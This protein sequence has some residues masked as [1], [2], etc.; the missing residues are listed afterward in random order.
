MQTS[1]S[2]QTHRRWRDKISSLIRRQCRTDDNVSVTIWA[3]MRGARPSKPSW[4]A[5]VPSAIGLVWVALVLLRYRVVYRGQWV[6]ELQRTDSDHVPICC[7]IAHDRT[8]ATATIS[9]ITARLPGTS[10]NA[11]P[12]LIAAL[13][14]EGFKL[15]AV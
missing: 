11:V 15:T 12:A 4:E 7:A 10:L 9:E 6:I 13:Q 14:A 5:F 3:Y 2:A 1:S 8:T